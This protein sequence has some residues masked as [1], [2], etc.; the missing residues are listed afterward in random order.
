MQCARGGAGSELSLHGW[1]A[2][3]LCS[4][5]WLTACHSRC[6][7]SAVRES[8]RSSNVETVCTHLSGHKSAIRDAEQQGHWQQRRTVTRRFTHL[9]DVFWVQSVGSLKSWTQLSDFTFTFHFDALEKEM[10]THSSVLAWRSPGMGEPGGL[11][12]M[13]SHRVG[14][15][16][17]NLAGAA[18]GHFNILNWLPPKL[19]SSSEPLLFFWVCLFRDIKPEKCRRVIL[20]PHFLVWKS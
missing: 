16:W 18:A 17:S 7:S 4:A 13:G 14:H 3:L 10:A 8:T 20:V 19:Q 9:F 15:D 2:A 11:P 6:D 12:S 5:H 1:L